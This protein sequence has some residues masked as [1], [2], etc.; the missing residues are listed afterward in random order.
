M[1]Q[2]SF[3][4]AADEIPPKVAELIFK[5]PNL[6]DLTV[7]PGYKQ[8][9]RFAKAIGASSGKTREP[10]STL[11]SVRALTILDSRW[12]FLAQICSNIQDLT[13]TASCRNIMNSSLQSHSLDLKRLGKMN[14]QLKRLH[15]AEHC[16][17]NLM[18]GKL[19]ILREST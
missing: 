1:V 18:E 19:K 15:F 14:P 2:R 12:Q 8:T 11:R 16:K 4:S 9:F 7:C 10:T 5:I 6:V 3:D 17:R 13:V